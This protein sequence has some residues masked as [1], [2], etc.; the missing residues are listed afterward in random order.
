MPD[1]TGFFSKVTDAY[2]ARTIASGVMPCRHKRLI[3]YW[4]WASVWVL[5]ASSFA[6]GAVLAQQPLT[7]E[8]LLADGWELVGYVAAWE[9]RSLILF[10]HR[11][12]K[13]LVQCSVLIDV[14]RAQHVVTA[15]YELK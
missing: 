12:H 3:R 7:I 11:D 10:R 4:I 2:Q 6:A 9:N 14:T 8:R 13:Y 15:C 1:W 5:L